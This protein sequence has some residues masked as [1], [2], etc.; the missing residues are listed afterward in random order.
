MKKST[1]QVTKEELDIL[2]KKFEQYIIPLEK[3]TVKFQVVL[4]N[5]RIIAFLDGTLEISGTADNV[6][7]SYINDILHNVSFPAIGVNISGKKDF[8]GPITLAT[9]VVGKK[10]LELL[11]KLELKKDIEVTDFLAMKYGKYLSTH[12]KHTVTIID[13]KKY[14]SYRKQN[15]SRGKVLM[16]Y[17]NLICKSI[18]KNCP[19]PFIIERYME[20][21]FFY[22]QVTRLKSFTNDIAFF[23]EANNYH[24]A[25]VVAGII[26]R[27]Y[28]LITMEK[29]NKLSD[30]FL[31]KGQ[32]VHAFNQ[33][34]ELIHEPFFWD[35]AKIDP[36]LKAKRKK[37]ENA[38]K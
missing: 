30:K 4:S 38:A 36:V 13:P 22:A 6:V 28:Y 24:V 2:E 21:K 35:I 34:K 33:Y 18:S 23:T 25:C 37:E 9:A 11:N 10:E 16:H 1:I 5:T 20:P 29:Y 7:I 14:N 32:N 19:Y 3:D 8:F 26:S 17:T 31:I 15:Y 12:I 27:Y